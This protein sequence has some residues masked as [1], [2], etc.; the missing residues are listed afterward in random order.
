ML[1]IAG[2]SDASSN[3]CDGVSRRDFLR[4]GTLAAMGTTGGWTL[5]DILRAD[6]IAGLCQSAAHPERR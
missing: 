6:A 5:P 1:T 3:Y 2:R 4:I